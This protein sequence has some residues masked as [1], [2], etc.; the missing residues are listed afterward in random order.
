M[1]DLHY[2]QLWD[3]QYEFNIN[4][5]PYYLHIQDNVLVDFS[6]YFCC[7]IICVTFVTTSIALQYLLTSMVR[8]LQKV[9]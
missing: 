7:T 1:Y 4:T 2:A 8:S 9:G 3:K 6:G 5:I